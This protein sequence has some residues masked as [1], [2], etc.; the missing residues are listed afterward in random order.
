[1]GNAKS[2]PATADRRKL[3]SKIEWEWE[4]ERECESRNPP[5][6]DLSSEQ[7]K[8]LTRAF[9]AKEANHLK[10]FVREIPL[11]AVRTQITGKT[12]YL[13]GEHGQR[14][15]HLLEIDFEQAKDVLTKAFAL[16]IDS[17]PSYYLRPEL[18]SGHERARTTGRQNDAKPWLNDLAI[19]RKAVKEKLNPIQGSISLQRKELIENC[20]IDAARIRENCFSSGFTLAP[21]AWPLPL[22]STLLRAMC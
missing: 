21:C 14:T 12:A 11:H 6:Q 2:S 5:F 8:R 22:S 17:R 4:L 9:I 7:L 1:M 13:W 19:Y 20:F 16:W 10:D 15:R 3:Q 18:G